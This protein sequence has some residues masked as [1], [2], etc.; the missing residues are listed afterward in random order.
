MDQL[1]IPT[2][3]HV[4]HQKAGS[5]WVAGVLREY[6]PPQ[7][8]E[9]A[10]NLAHFFERP[11]KAG[12]LYPTIYIPTN[13]FRGMLLAEKTKFNYFPANK[14][15][16]QFS[17][18]VNWL[19]FVLFKNRYKVFVVIRDLRDTLISLYF[20]VLYSH[21]ENEDVRY[22]RPLLAQ[23][24]LDEGLALLINDRLSRHAQIQLSW[25]KA[26]EKG[27]ALFVRYEDMLKDPYSVFAEIMNYCEVPVDEDRLRLIVSRN[28]FEAMTGRE[29]GEEDLKAHLRKGIQGDWRHYFSEPVKMEFK[30][31][32]GDLLIATQYETNNNW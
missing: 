3:F 22:F 32:F 19:N 31:K 27:E 16:R 21:E 9:A 11:I 7:F 5:Q 29:R 4:T 12:C 18:C 1:S 15:R 13:E 14:V 28:S 2:V 26:S 6:L 23:R 24:D 25:L 10:P 8:V 30:R 20:S 17:R